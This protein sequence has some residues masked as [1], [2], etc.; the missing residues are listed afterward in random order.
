MGLA[1]ILALAATFLLPDNPYIRY[2]QARDSVMFHAAWVYERIH[3]DRAPIDVAV[4]GSSHLEAGIS[5]TLLSDQL[6][7]RLKRPVHA[8]NLSLVKPGRDYTYLVIRDLLDKHPETKLIVLSDDGDAMFT[9]PMFKAAADAKDIVDAPLIVNT[10]YFDNLLYLPY[11][12]V[13]YAAQAMA[14]AAFG[15]TPRFD[16]SH[17]LGT[18]L[19]R[20]LGYRAPTGEFVNGDQHASEPQLRAQVEAIKAGAGG[21]ALHFLNRLPPMEAQPGEWFYIQRI[22]DLCRAHG[23]KLV[24]VTIP[25]YGNYH[26]QTDDA[27]YARFGDMVRIGDVS[28]QPN[29]YWNGGHLNRS[30]AIVATNQLAAQIGR[31]EEVDQARAAAETGKNRNRCLPVTV[32]WRCVVSRLVSLVPNRVNE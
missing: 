16:P 13:S 8:V 6:T 9:H 20:T 30:G 17:Y 4:V 11:R 26:P 14:P 2:Q 23:V 22:S 32:S 3:F 27:S 10:K 24:F 18:D 21:G 1:A 19:D 5:P 7:A 15:V 28:T 31:F 29:D 12:N 25:L